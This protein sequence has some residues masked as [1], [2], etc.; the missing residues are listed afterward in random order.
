MALAIR[1]ASV[2]VWRRVLVFAMPVQRQARA[3]DIRRAATARRLRR[4]RARA[5]AATRGDGRAHVAAHVAMNRAQAGDARLERRQLLGRRLVRGRARPAAS[6]QRSTSSSRPVFTPSHAFVRQRFG[7]WTTVSEGS[8][9][10]QLA[11]VSWRP[12]WRNSYQWV[13]ISSIVSPKSPAAVAC[14]IAS[15]I[16]LGV[17]IPRRRAAVKLGDEPRPRARELVAQQFGEQVVI[18]VPLAPGIEGDDERVVALQSSQQPLGV[19]VSGHRRA[20]RPRKSVQDRAS[21]HE[22]A[23]LRRLAV[24]DLESEVVDDLLVVSGEGVDELPVVLAAPQRQS[25]ELKPGRPPLRPLVQPRD[26]V[27]RRGHSPT[28]SFKNAPASVTLNRR[29]APRISVS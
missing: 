22:L 12:R 14:S 29:S 10:I 13:V 4:A 27:R 18:A 25:G 19:W 5:R 23:Q 6:I 15:W 26:L 8:W 28:T 24:E 7:S 17:A 2:S 1:T 20:Q 11:T 16:A 9:S 3:P 21:D